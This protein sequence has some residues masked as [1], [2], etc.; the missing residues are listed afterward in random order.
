MFY[1]TKGKNMKKSL[2]ITLI[3]ICAILIVYLALV[4]CPRSNN[5]K[6]DNSMRTDSEL[7]ILIEV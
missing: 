1:M 5:Y 7:P 4:I 3:V 2:K 6:F